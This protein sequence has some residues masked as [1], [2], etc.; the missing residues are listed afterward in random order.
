VCI[1]LNTQLRKPLM[2]SAHS[3]IRSVC[4]PFL[5]VIQVKE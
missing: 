1:Y 3:D 4:Y 2:F 5:Q